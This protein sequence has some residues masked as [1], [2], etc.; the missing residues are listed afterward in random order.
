MKR[1]CLAMLIAS[2]ALI[3]SAVLAQTS[4]ETAPAQ[5]QATTQIQ[6]QN[7]A[8]PLTVASLSDQLIYDQKG[9]EFGRVRGVVQNQNKQVFAIVTLT[10]N[11]QVLVPV[12]LISFRLLFQGSGQ[13]LTEY[14]QGSNEYQPITPQEQALATSE[15]TRMRTPQERQAYLQRFGGNITAKPTE[16]QAAMAVRE[17]KGK[18]IWNTQGEQLGKVDDVV[19]IN[20]KPHIVIAHGGFLG[21]G[22]DKV[23]FPLDRFVRSGDNL[24]IHGIIEQDI[25]AMDEW[26]TK[27]DIANAK[28]TDSVQ[29]QLPQLRSQ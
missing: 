12:E 2:T 20:N 16:T 10:D 9:Q 28:L 29:L 24:I 19:M 14:K 4:S 11:R 21:I 23:A 17:I 26:Q 3:P 22:E 8:R 15:Q 27:A 18:E 25:E 1:T 13:K 5:Q 6:Q 7:Q